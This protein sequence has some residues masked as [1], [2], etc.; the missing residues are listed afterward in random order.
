MARV[1]KIT[2]CC[3]L[4]TIYITDDSLPP[5]FPAASSW[6]L[7]TC[8]QYILISPQP[9]SPQNWFL[10]RSTLRVLLY[11]LKLPQRILMKSQ[12]LHT[13]P[14]S[15]FRGEMRRRIW[16]VMHALDVMTSLLLGNVSRQSLP[17]G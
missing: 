1:P 8:Q 14:A 11:R 3:Q 5:P 12:I 16:A 4:A 15:P 10:I 6:Q 7:I 17:P 2:Q 13:F 9:L